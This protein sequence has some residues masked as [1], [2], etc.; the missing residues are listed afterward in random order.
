MKIINEIYKIINDETNLPK[1]FVC[2]LLRA[3]FKVISKNKVNALGNNKHAS[4]K[5]LE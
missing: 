2:F 5:K 3:K 1:C 4:T